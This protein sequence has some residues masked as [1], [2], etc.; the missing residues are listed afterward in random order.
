MYYSFS[1]TFFIYPLSLFQ[2]LFPFIRSFRFPSYLV[3]FG[4]SCVVA[5]VTLTVSAPYGFGL[6]RF[7]WPFCLLPLPFPVLKRL[8]EVCAYPAL[9][10]PFSS[11]CYRSLGSVLSSGSIWQRVIFSY[12]R[13]FILHYHE[14][15]QFPC[16]LFLFLGNSI[17]NAI[18]SQ[19]ARWYDWV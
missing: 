19:E 18:F 12:K 1:C 15:L 3:H 7:W 17:A 5:A 13:S 14:L 4:P 9:L 8:F 10:S 6:P 2:A 11:V 16:M